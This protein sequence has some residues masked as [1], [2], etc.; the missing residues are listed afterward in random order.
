MVTSSKK[1]F[2]TLTIGL[3]GALAAQYAGL[4]APA[5]IGSTLAVSG[6]SLLR[7]TQ[8]IP[9]FLKNIAFTVIGCSLGSSITPETLADSSKWPLSLTILGI[10]VIAIIYFCST[11]LV[12]YFNKSRETAILAT[13][14]GALAYALALASDGKADIRSIAVIQ[15]VRLVAVLTTIPIILTH[16][17]MH[18]EQSPTVGKES[19]GLIAFSALFVGSLLIGWFFSRIKIPAAFILA[20]IFVSGAAHLSGVVVGRPAD[21]IIFIGF[22]ITGS[23]VGARFSTIPLEDL[24]NLFWGSISALLL[25]LFIAAIFA[26]AVAKL[27]VLPFGQVFVAFA[28]GGVEAMAAMALSLNYDPA[29]V[30]VH[31]LFRIFFLILILP[32][33][34]RK[35]SLKRKK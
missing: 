14:P 33:F 2:V 16:F 12:K 34:L 30:A 29:Y 23:L 22:T 20:G 7:L 8:D 19:M 17:G 9:H 26:A 1:M 10:A 35:S 25:S 32:F 21:E 13:S 27:L 28:P 18:P 4:P 6:A 24:K 3:I 11:I 15:S 5:I 31:H